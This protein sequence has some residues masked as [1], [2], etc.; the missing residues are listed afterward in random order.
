[1]VQAVLEYQEHSTVF[2]QLPDQML[3]WLKSIV[4]VILEQCKIWM[5]LIPNKKKWLS[6]KAELRSNMW[7]G[8]CASPL[9][10]CL[11]P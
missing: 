8:Y 9:C 2:F 6:Q 11:E 1:M 4:V 5:A 3:F 7:M 10:A